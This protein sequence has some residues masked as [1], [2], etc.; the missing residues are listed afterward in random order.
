MVYEQLAHQEKKPM[1]YKV[2]SEKI[3][4]SLCAP[5]GDKTARIVNEN[6]EIIAYVESIEIANQIVDQANKK[7]YDPRS[8]QEREGDPK[9]V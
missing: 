3:S 1:K 2:I 4:G 6:G 5:W 7:C 8:E 9:W